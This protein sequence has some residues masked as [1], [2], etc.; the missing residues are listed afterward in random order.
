MNSILTAGKGDRPRRVKRKKYDEGYD[1]I[2]GNK[3][4]APS[5]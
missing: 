4:K 5:K 3:K 1:R 2:F